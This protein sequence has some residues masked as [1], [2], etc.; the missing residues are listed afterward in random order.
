MRAVATAQARYRCA[1]EGSLR[2]RHAKAPQKVRA[3]TRPSACQRRLRRSRAERIGEAELVAC[4]RA[5]R[6]CPRVAARAPQASKLSAWRLFVSGRS[7]IGSGIGPRAL[8]VQENLQNDA[9]GDGN[10]DVVGAGLHPVVPTRR[11]TQAT[12][13]PIVDHIA[14]AAVLGWE[15][16][17]SMERV[18]RPCAPLEIPVTASFATVFASVRSILPMAKCRSGLITATV[19]VVVPLRLISSLVPG[20][21][22]AIP[23]KDGRYH[24]H[25]HCHPRSRRHHG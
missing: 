22:S 11:C 24:G 18:V 3:A 5:E 17:A 6:A 14:A 10:Q 4:M 2:A 12:R 8:I 25:R 15:A 16:T 19:S 1:L 20:A 13:T 7:A 9:G 23:S 21:I